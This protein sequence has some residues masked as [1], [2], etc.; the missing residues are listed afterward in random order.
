MFNQT[1]AA[2]KDYYTGEEFYSMLGSADNL[3]VQVILDAAT[4]ASTTVTVKYEANNTSQEQMW[5][6]TPASDVVAITALTQL[7]A[8]TTFEAPGEVA[9][10]MAYGRFS[11]RSNQQ[12]SA[13]RIVVCGRSR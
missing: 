5:V 1:I 12:G 6:I 11:V 8:Q 3:V 7:P 4:N 2:D 13:V 10:P 9:L